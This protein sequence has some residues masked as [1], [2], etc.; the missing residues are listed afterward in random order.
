MEREFIHD[1]SRFF[2][3]VATLLC[4]VDSFPELGKPLNLENPWE[5][6]IECTECLW[7]DWTS[8]LKSITNKIVVLILSQ[9][10]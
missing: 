9:I 1:N 7:K 3:T 5:T 8:V 6:I 2:V 4:M 10:K